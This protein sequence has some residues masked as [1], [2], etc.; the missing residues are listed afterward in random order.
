MS[1]AWAIL[2]HERARYLPA[3]F[4]VA[5]SALLMLMQTGLLLGIFS[6]LAVPIE[7]S[8]AHVWIGYPGV[9]SVDYG[10]TIPE[11]FVARVANQPEVARVESYVR[12][13]VIWGLP[14]GGV[15][16]VTVIG[17]RLGEGA[18]GPVEQLSP[19]LR[20]L[21]AEPG[22]IVVDSSELEGLGLRGVGA[23]NEVNGCR[24]RVV[25]TIAYLKGTTGAY[26]FCSVETARRLLR[27]PAHQTTYVV[28]ACRDA[29]EA[30][31][32]VER[33]RRYPN[34]SSF[35]SAEF[36]RRSRTHWM[37]KTKL[38]VALG[39]AALLGLLVGG[40]VTSQTL[41]AATVAS[42]KQYA[43]LEALGIPTWR[44]VLLVL[45]HALG[46]GLLGTA[47]AVPAALALART[48]L[49]LGGKF[50]MPGGIGLA[51]LGL[52][53]AMALLSGLWALRSLRLVEPTALLR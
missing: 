14:D 7:H 24:V 29:S 13:L 45:T 38:G 33:L 20:A 25:G 27:L 53:L 30:P 48:V 5:F 42:V 37:T 36:A 16:I 2:W 43:V 49:A 39:F 22:A 15:E 17:T 26:V 52:A 6:E 19:E 32:V 3:V 18:I 34:M 8:R 44:M 1:H 51:I 12:G 23:V 28:A 21:L 10:K 4:A 31:A 40:A 47:L 11:E 41:Y 46:V 35:T 9:P 50:L